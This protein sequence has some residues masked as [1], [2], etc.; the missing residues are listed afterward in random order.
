M[1]GWPTRAAPSA[2]SGPFTT[3]STPG[4][5]AAAMAAATGSTVPGQVGGALTT[6]V[7]PVSRAGSTLLAMTETGQ[8]KGRSA[9]TTPCGT[10]S[11]RVARRRRAGRPG[12]RRPGGRR[13][14]PWRP[15]W[16]RRRWPPSAPCRARGSAGGPGPALHRRHARLG[17][18]HD[19]GRPARPGRGR[20][21]PVRPAGRRHR[22][23]EL[24]RAWPPGHR[25]RPR[26]AGRVGHRVGARGPGHHLAVDHQADAR[27]A[28]CRRAVWSCAPPGAGR[29]A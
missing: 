12:P 28:T 10:H 5:R 17:G 6:T 27:S 2:A 3:L 8:L 25:G 11:M 26:P 20:P 24:G 1:S 15:W 19:R 23:V 4:G 29:L 9:A 18:G 13:P 16:R 7:L 14:R 22:Q 21:R